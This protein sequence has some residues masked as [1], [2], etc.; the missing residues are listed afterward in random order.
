LSTSNEF[1]CLHC[2][3]CCKNAGST[4]R[5]EQVDI[6]RWEREG[7][8]DIISKVFLTSLRC[9]ACNIE[10]GALCGNTCP[11]CG[12][13]G[14]GIFYWIDPEEP[15][16]YFSQLMADPKCPFLR[17]MRNVNEYTCMINETKPIICKEFPD[18]D[19]NQTTK[20]ENE[21][22]EWECKGYLR[23]REYNRR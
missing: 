9:T 6:E 1:K 18:L 5:I 15:K 4:L 7:R 8:N 3:Q 16:D 23:W 13:V 17:K 20:N 21:C 19:K 22:I 14:V 2:G 11:E 10:W 12:Q